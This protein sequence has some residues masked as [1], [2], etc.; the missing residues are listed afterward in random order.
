[1]YKRFKWVVIGLLCNLICLSEFTKAAFAG[2]NPPTYAKVTVVRNPQGESF[3]ELRFHWS[4]EKPPSFDEGVAVEFEIHVD[5]KCFVRPVGGKDDNHVCKNRLKDFDLPN[6]IILPPTNDRNCYVDVW[7]Y[8]APDAIG[9][10]SSIEKRCGSIGNKTAACIIGISSMDK[11]TDKDGN[12]AVGLHEANKLQFGHSYFFRYPVEINNSPECLAKYGDNIDE[13]LATVN[14]QTFANSCKIIPRCTG[15]IPPIFSPDDTVDIPFTLPDVDREYYCPELIGASVACT[16]INKN[17]NIW[18][19]NLCVP[20]DLWEFAPGVSVV[21]NNNGTCEGGNFVEGHTSKSCCRDSDNDGYFKRQ[22]SSGNIEI[23]TSGTKAGDCDDDNSTIHPGADEYS[24]GID[25]DCDGNADLAA[26]VDTCPKDAECAFLMEVVKPCPN[27]VGISHKI[28][29]KS[30]VWETVSVCPVDCTPSQSTN[31]GNCGQKI[32]DGN[33]QWGTCQNQGTCTAG[34]TEQQTCNTSGTK[35]RICETNCQWSAWGQCSFNP[36]CTAGQTQTQACTNGTSAGTQ[37]QTCTAQGQWSAW[38]TCEINAVCPNGAT[39]SCGNCGTQTCTGGLWAA[40][41]NQG[42]CTAGQTEQQ[43]C[44]GSGT[45]TRT[46]QS[47]CIW[48]NWGTCSTTN[49]ACSSGDCCDGC[50]YYNSSYSC[51][52]TYSYQCEGSSAGQNAQQAIVRQYCSGNSTD[53]D[54]QSQQFGWSTLEDCSTAQVCQMSGGIPECVPIT[55][56][57]D[58]YIADLPQSC[59]TS[60]GTTNTIKLCLNLNQVSGSTW[61]YQLCRVGAYSD[62]YAYRLNDDSYNVSFTDYIG[63]AADWCTTKRQV[64][65]NYLTSGQKAGLVGIVT[66]PVGCASSACRYRSGT[67]AVTKSCL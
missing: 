40:C 23:P 37:T 64:V 36:V 52:Q 65:L 6:D 63:N 26:S 14:M 58:T 46:C 24:D 35:S 33:G 16:N 22:W 54:G 67:I 32:C 59:Y 30:C 7:N 19:N 18:I 8:W 1:M 61:E 3:L 17:D 56:C 9:L 51:N 66:Y 2:Y 50:N 55:T 29:N 25:S 53:C 57:T 44:N 13:G 21:T 47:S 10:V 31:C 27:G 15:D 20:T 43:T 62:S 28:C 60:S 45:Q 39:Q 11:I 42:T 38:G 5:N 12:F 34:Q 49:C 48:G 41:L 4:S